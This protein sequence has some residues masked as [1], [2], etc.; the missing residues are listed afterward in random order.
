MV[1]RDAAR[2]ANHR[3]FQLSV[4]TVV[5]IGQ[6]TSALRTAFASVSA[7]RK[8][9]G[10]R[11]VCLSKKEGSTPRPLTMVSVGTA[12]GDATNHH[13][14]GNRPSVRS[15]KGYIT[16]CCTMLSMA[17]LLFNQVHPVEPQSGRLAVVRTV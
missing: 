13:S 16:N 14:D 17:S 11:P 5:V 15:A 6:E 12:C 8:Q 2:R 4:K 7:V 10:S 1:E 3:P 9:C